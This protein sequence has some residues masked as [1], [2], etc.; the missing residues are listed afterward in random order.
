MSHFDSICIDP[1]QRT[2]TVGPCALGQSLNE[3]AAEHGLC[4]PTG[5]CV[6]VPVGGFLLGGGL[7]WFIPHYGYAAE[8]L[9]A[10]TVVDASGRVVEAKADSNEEAEEERTSESEEWM[11]LARG[12]ASAFPGVVVSFK[13][14]L[15]PL[16]KV[17]KSRL[18]LY[19]LESFEAMVGFFHEYVMAH[20][21]SSVKL[22]LTAVMACT[23]PPLV[24][25]VKVPK[26]LMV[27]VVGIADSV[28]EF[29]SMVRPLQ[30]APAA[31]FF[32][33]AFEDHESF[34]SLPEL[35]REAY[36]PGT[37][38]ANRCLLGGPEQFRQVDWTRFRESFV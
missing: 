3:K 17:I 28:E 35:L 27:M 12:A 31:P 6:G 8:S 29:D 15:H 11:W 32:P 30:E 33:S 37:H 1:A 19:P 26:L 4:F 36:P 20:P 2:A 38:W 22:E 14:R 16:P 7:G 21:E 5:H 23:P 10:V 9:L 34:R 18:E 24:D 13:V 25:V